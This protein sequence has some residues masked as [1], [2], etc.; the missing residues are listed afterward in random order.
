MQAVNRRFPSAPVSGA[1]TLQARKPMAWTPNTLKLKPVALCVSAVLASLSAGAQTRPPAGSP[2][3]V[4]YTAVTGEGAALYPRAP[5]QDLDKP[6]L[7]RAPDGKVDYAA[8]ARV[9]RILV[10]VERDGVPADGQSAV[11]V[12]L[13]LLDKA[14]RSVTGV[15]YAT[16][17]HSGG[18]IL[19]PGASTDELGPGRIDADR[20]TPGVQ[21]KVEAGRAEFH[22]LAPAEPQDVRLRI[23]AG[24]EEVSGSVA[25]VPDLRQL[26]AAGLIEGVISARTRLNLQTTRRGDPFEQEIQAW[27]RDFAGGRGAIATRTEFFLKGV[28]RGDMLLTAAYDSDKETRTR[29]LRDVR[30]EEMYPV[31]GD[32]SLRSFD[33]RSASRLY[34][35]VDKGKNYALY[36]D[37][38]TG[39]GFTQPI[40]EG[41]V[42]SLKQRSLGNYNRS[43]TGVRL[44]QERGNVTANV[45]AF[46]DSLRQVVE[47]IASQ[48]SGPYGLRNNGLLEGSDKVEVI[49]RDRQQTSRIISV[50]PLAR[51]VDYSFEPFSGRILLASFLP[52]FD[53]NLNPVSLRITYEVDQGGEAFWVVGGDAQV[54]LNAAFEVGGSAV[55]DRNPLAPYDLMSGNVTWRLGPR[56]AIVLEGAQST[57]TVNTNSVNTSTAAGLAGQSGEL[58]GRAARLEYVHDD[59]NTQARVL[60]ARS[61]PLFNNPAA[62]LIGGRDE[63]AASGSVHFTPSFK[64]YGDAN[65]SQ[66]RNAGG[67]QRTGGGFGLRWT[68]ERLTLD[69]GLRTARETVG[70]RPNGS[71][72]WPYDQTAGLSSSLA[73][74]AGGG[75]LGYGNQTLDPATGLPVIRQAGLAP[76]VTSIAA[77]TR[78]SSNLLRLGAGFRVSDNLSLGG[79]LEHNITGD[80]RQRLA[81]GADYA[82]AER[83]RLYGRYELQNGWVSQGGVSDV[84]HTAGTFVAGVSSS[85]L[86]DTQLFSEYRLRDAVSGRDL[87]LASGVRNHWN[88]AEGLNL[89]SA[90]E[91]VKVLSGAVAPVSAVSLGLDYSASPLWRGSAKVEWRRSGDVS[92]TPTV[93]EAFDTTLLQVMAARKLD[94]DWTALARH[95]TLFTNYVARGDVQQHRSQL[96]LAWRDT[97]TNLMNALGKIELKR[98]I[99]ESGAAACG[100]RTKAVIGSL[101]ADVHPARP[102]WLTGRLAAK[103]QPDRFE[104]CV[105]DSFKAVLGAARLTYDI[106]ENWDMGLMGSL[107]AGQAGARQKSLGLEMGYLMQQNLWLSAGYNAAGYT[108]DPDLIGYEYTR[109]GVFLRLRFK[110][111][112]NLFKRGDA[113]VNRSLNR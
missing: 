96:G 79:E 103:N 75:A 20:A 40:G 73:S 25:F 82:F 22:L 45:F 86:R 39:D 2:P 85:Y 30:P 93:N 17:E 65:R 51:M 77:G 66:D 99:D 15:T 106:T 92:N 113:D 74:G 56:T 4:R 48:G 18:R 88:V 11:K 72:S 78:L 95:Y 76:A 21:I 102:W 101:L 37:Y 33:A 111:D 53:D 69:A 112:E 12:V 67:G 41:A 83:T 43:A 80:K 27:S 3:D 89:T 44:H 62:P 91:H 28:I 70:T 52:A 84:G 34:V 29:L 46:R 5:E 97:D 105:P 55:T 108:G 54:K 81:L 58:K 110:F 14:G 90:L 1:L 47:E 109:R 57:S 35:R 32:A 26:V 9:A 36:G 31:Y 23:T 7:R 42:A 16:L 38:V 64:L 87:Q 10:E 107:F 98:E 61:S 104:N 19:L 59:A 63:L 8:S 60:L 71:L 13:R 49:V 100:V 50:R 94:R 6:I 68:G 24:S